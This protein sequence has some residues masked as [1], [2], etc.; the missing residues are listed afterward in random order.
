MKEKRESII[1]RYKD[2]LKLKNYTEESIYR[3]ILNL[4][5]YFKYLDLVNTEYDR[6]TFKIAEDY[7]G[8]LVA[9]K[10][11]SRGTINNRLNR[12]RC[13]YRFLVLKE[14]MAKNP[15]KD[16]KSL[17]MGFILPK[18]ILSVSDMG[19]LLDNFSIKNEHDLLLKSVAEIM[20][21]SGLRINEAVRLKDSNID[22]EK[23][24]IIIN[25]SKTGNGERKV[26]TNRNALNV[27][28]MYL[29]HSREKVMNQKEMEE[30][31]IYPQVKVGSYV[32]SLNRKL[33]AECER[34]GLKVI[35]SHGFRHSVATH[36]FKS[37]AGIKEVQEFLGHKKIGNTEI[38]THVL[39]DDL[40]KVINKYHPR[41]E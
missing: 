37:G 26:I 3:Y 6:A 7:R 40:K 39:K 9:D 25:E 10:K 2:Y 5:D 38:Y 31:Y 12:V 22:Y 8:Y 23:E 13:F 14:E 35:T 15:F 4:E 29:R 34:L 28:K 21:G 16:V 18:S 36:I 32:V 24:S 19:M 20:Y 1:Q 27:L 17:R 11:I 30:G 41:G 33:K